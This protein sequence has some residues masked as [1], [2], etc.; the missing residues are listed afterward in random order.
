MYGKIKN[1]HFVGIGGIGMSGI[2]E[3]LVNMGYEISGSDI[4]DSIATRRLQK[5]GIKIYVGHDASNVKDA[6][7]VVISSAIGKTN[8]ELV[9][10][11]KE[12]IPVVARAEMLAELMRLKYGIA[13]IGSHGKT[14]TT[15][16]VSAVLRAGHLDPTIVVGGRVKSLGTNAHLGK[17]DFMVV[18]ADESDG[19][20]QMLSPVISVLTNIDEEHLDHYGSIEN[21]INSFSVFIDKIPFYGLAVLC[22]DCPKVKKIAKNYRKRS[23]TYG[24]T[25][26]ADLYF[27]NF[28]AKGFKTRFEVIYRGN[29]LGAVELGIPGKHNALNAL[30]AIGVGL[31]L[32]ISFDDIGTALNEFNGIERRLQLKGE[33]NEILIIDDYGHHPVEIKTTL[34]SIEEAFQK[35]P[36]VIFQPH[37]YTRT[38]MLFN[39]FVNVLS[40]IKTL[41]VLDIYPA[42]E[43]PIEGIN[44]EILVQEINRSGSNNA[45]YI[46]DID[47]LF[48]HVKTNINSGDIILT[49]GAGNV[50]K[51]GEELLRELQ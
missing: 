51:H 25:D 18:E 49:S 40:D 42:G 16:I 6:D 39:D 34:K 37:R 47:D 30:A 9:K 46:K 41:Y 1:L 23:L 8:P 14:T 19:S 33:V 12:N 5:L 13:I 31:E 7:V 28:S 36:V 11:H 17:G 45:Y 15:S 29:N 50:W 10:A 2:A 32:G 35:K 44:S 27:E 24:F 38:Q 4:N 48:E 20:F 43:K 3:V 22:I 21:L 26:E